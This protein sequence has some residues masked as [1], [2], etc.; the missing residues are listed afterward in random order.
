MAPLNVK[1]DNEIISRFK[2]KDME[3]PYLQLVKAQYEAGFPLNSIIYKDDNRLLGG[4]NLMPNCASC[5]ILTNKRIIVDA[6]GSLYKCH[7]MTGRKDWAVGNVFDGVD[8][9]C[10]SYRH[11]T[12]PYIDEE[13]CKKCNILPICN[14]GCRANRI[15]YGPQH[16]C[17]K[18]KQVQSELV[19]LY[20]NRLKGE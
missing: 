3:H 6:D 4:F 10:Y 14:G 13:S 12:S 9:E 16:K 20:Y 7:R 19:K 11:F 18:I 5:G 8:T 15:L 17:H 2:G 1:D